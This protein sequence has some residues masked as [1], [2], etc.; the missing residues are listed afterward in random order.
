MT[1]EL[2][3]AVAVCFMG[4]GFFA[5]ITL[6]IDKIKKKRNPPPPC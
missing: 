1:P 4:V 5:G 6:I 2:L 3:K